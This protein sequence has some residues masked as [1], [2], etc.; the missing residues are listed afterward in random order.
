MRKPRQIRRPEA[1]TPHNELLQIKLEMLSS[2]FQV[3]IT[4]PLKHTAKHREGAYVSIEEGLLAG[5]E[6]SSMKRC[7][8]VHAAQTEHLQFYSLGRSDRHTLRTNRLVLRGL[9]RSAG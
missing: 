7:A 9:P 8:A 5:T 1:P 2:T 4:Q 6:V 3:V